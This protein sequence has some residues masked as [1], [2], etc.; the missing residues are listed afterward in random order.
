MVTPSFTNELSDQLLDNRVGVCAI[1]IASDCGHEE[2]IAF[3][4]DKTSLEKKTKQSE[5]L[6]DVQAIN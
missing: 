4:R 5:K 6:N 3:L 2:V 1:E